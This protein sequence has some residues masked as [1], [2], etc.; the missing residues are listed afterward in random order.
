MNKKLCAQV[1]TGHISTKKWRGV[2]FPIHI[3]IQYEVNGREYIIKDSLKYYSEP[4]KLG[5]FPIGQRK[6]PKLG[7]VSIGAPV[8]VA[9]NPEDPSM[10]YLPDNQGILNA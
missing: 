5:K 2:N 4:I 9:Y 1:T 8:R 7:N 6:V 3:E 10:A